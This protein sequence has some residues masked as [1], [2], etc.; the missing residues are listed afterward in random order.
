[1]ENPDNTHAIAPTKEHT[2]T[3]IFLHGRDSTAAEFA[4]EFFETL[5]TIVQ[6]IE[7]VIDALPAIL[8]GAF[9]QGVMLMH[10]CKEGQCSACK[11]FLIDGDGDS[12]ARPQRP[13]VAVVSPIRRSGN[14]AVCHRDQSL[15]RALTAAD[16]QRN[17]LRAS[18]RQFDVRCR[19]FFSLPRR[20]G[21]YR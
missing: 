11:S 7:H 10:G 6:R 14:G 19:A 2:H 12:G 20:D 5:P 4:D 1:M 21:S 16:G 17:R 3:V 15:L 18:A 13:G 9:R 8:D